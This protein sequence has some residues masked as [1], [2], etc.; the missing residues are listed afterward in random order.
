[1]NVICNIL[2]TYYVGAIG[3]MSNEQVEGH[4]ISKNSINYLVDFSVD[5]KK[6]NYVGDYSKKLVNR[7]ECVEE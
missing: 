6:H 5:A 7:N 3:F 1:M 2:V 4:V